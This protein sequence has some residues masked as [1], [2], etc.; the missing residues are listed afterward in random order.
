MDLSKNPPRRR[1]DPISQRLVTTR[2]TVVRGEQARE[3][4][5]G[6]RVSVEEEG[7]LRHF[8][9]HLAEITFIRRNLELPSGEQIV[10]DRLDEL[11][12]GGPAPIDGRR[13][14]SGPSCNRR[15]RCRFEAVFDQ[16]LTNGSENN[17]LYG[18]VTRSPATSTG[19]GG[20]GTG[21]FGG[22]VDLQ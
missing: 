5:S 10:E 22:L 15:D 9:D 12:L 14:D 2:V 20:G 1:L 16:G 18:R 13:S 17:C 19:G 11:D 7:A 4:P 8:P 6:C 21:V 3:R